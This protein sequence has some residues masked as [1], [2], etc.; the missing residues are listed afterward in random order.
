MTRVLFVDDEIPVL[1]ALRARLHRMRGRFEMDFVES[2][3][4]ALEAFERQPYDIL[5]TDIRMPGMDGAQLMHEVCKRWPETVR[6]ALSGFAELKQSMRLV[7]LAHQFLSKPCEPQQ[8]ESVIQRCL[9]LRDLLSSTDLR[10]AVG[11]FQRLPTLP[12]TYAKL[13]PVLAREDSTAQ[14]VAQ[15]LAGDSVIVAKV[16]QL[17]NS[18]FFRLPR[19]LTNVAQAVAY[20]GFTSVRNLVLSAEVFASWSRENRRTVVD[21]ERLQ[22]H[23]HSVAAVS[24][25]LT[26]FMPIADDSVLAGLLHDIGY[27]VLAQQCPER[28]ESAL[29]LAITRGVPMSEAERELIGASHAEIGA[30][31]LG[32]WGLPY[33]IVEA[34]ANHHN[35]ERV[36]PG[37]LD[38]LAALTVASTL[39]GSNEV[40]VFQRTPPPERSV[41][42]AYLESVAAPFDW[43][44]ARRRAIEALETQE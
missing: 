11:R 30:Y 15:V 37:E 14:E 10:T 38:V 43:N 41:E 7:P 40:G 17:V 4:D 29:D 34:V 8:L 35:P 18:A 39:T 32:I 27:W 5:V 9:N 22:G 44:E 23:V 24:H 21:L 19:R 42:P 6:I 16:L 20:L 3:T 13:E 33:S 25:S 36:A 28:L 12:G 26:A 2:G 31:L 1:E